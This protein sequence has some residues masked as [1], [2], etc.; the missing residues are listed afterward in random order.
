MQ[1]IDLSKFEVAPPDGA[2]NLTGRHLLVLREDHLPEGIA[3]LRSEGF[4]V[5][6]SEADDPHVP[7]EDEVG[8]AT[9]IVLSALGVAEVE[10]TPDQLIRLQDAVAHAGP[11]LIVQAEKVR[12]ILPF[13]SDMRARF[14]ELEL[15]SSAA[16]ST[17]TD[18]DFP[19]DETT[20]TWGLQA[21]KAIDSKFSGAGVRVAILD[22]GIDLTV[23]E[24]GRIQY[25]PD[26]DG[27]TIVSSSFMR[28]LSVAKDGNGHGT[29]CVGIACGSRHPP[30]QPRYGVACD[31]EIYVGK[32][33]ND[34][35]FGPDLW[36]VAGLEWAV[37]NKCHIV[38]IS[39][40]GE[41]KKEGDP[42]NQAYEEIAKRALRMGTLM[43]AAAGNDSDRPGHVSAVV[44]P[45]D[46]PSIIAVG[47]IDQSLKQLWG[48]SNGGLNPNGG[49]INFAAP[50]VEILSSFV[51]PPRDSKSGTSVATP[52]VAGIAALYA[53]A[54]PGV[55]GTGLRNLL[56]KSAA[57]LP[58]S[59]IDV[60]YGLVQAP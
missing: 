39:L 9:A 18:A 3:F 6:V 36:T 24:N 27:R 31:S 57:S 42:F 32:V 16:D 48:K 5:F 17:C 55:V 20:A 41:P 2:D 4:K 7:R 56:N 45:A 35:C 47:A 53:E 33:A 40:G 38:S 14:A 51:L 19:F 23:K 29:H 50:G 8:D 59:A 58:L 43:I 21:T 52:F 37:R 46:C 49:E 1:A 13:S 10:A 22:T 15:E 54:N 30:A 12:S 25:H 60:G 26:F 34:A 11:V 28:G 44:G